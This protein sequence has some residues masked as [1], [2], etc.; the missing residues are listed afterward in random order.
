MPKHEI[1][2]KFYVDYYKLKEIRKGELITLPKL[3]LFQVR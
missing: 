3:R 2:S 1:N